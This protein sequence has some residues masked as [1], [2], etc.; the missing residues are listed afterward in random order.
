MNELLAT[1][2]N[3]KLVHEELVITIIKALTGS[4]DNQTCWGVFSDKTISSAV[5][6]YHVLVKLPTIAACDALADLLENEPVLAGVFGGY[7]VI[8]AT[9]NIVRCPSSSEVRE[10]VA[11]ADATTGS[12]GS[13]TLTCERLSAAVSVPEWNVAINATNGKS[14]QD[15]EQFA[16]RTCTPH[17]KQYK[18]ISKAQDNNKSASG[19]NKTTYLQVIKPNVFVIDFV[20]ERL[21]NVTVQAATAEC[22]ARGIASRSGFMSALR[23]TARFAPSFIVNGS[24]AGELQEVT[25]ANIM[26]LAAGYA[27]SD[28]IDD[29]ANRIPFSEALFD[30]ATA[31][32][33]NNIQAEISVRRTITTRATTRDD[34]KSEQETDKPENTDNNDNAA[35]TGDNTLNDNCD[36]QARSSGDAINNQDPN[37]L[38]RALNA[39]TLERERL[40]RVKKQRAFFARLGYYAVLVDK[41]YDSLSELLDECRATPREAAK[42][43][44]VTGMN[45]ADCELIKSAIVGDPRV[46]VP[47]DNLV[48]NM[49]RRINDPKLTTREK[50]EL[51]TRSFARLGNSEIITPHNIALEMVSAFSRE[52]VREIISH[53]ERI[54]ELAS[55]TGEFAIAVVERFT[56]LGFALGEYKGLVCAVPASSLAFECTRKVFELL[57]LDPDNVYNFTTYDLLDMIAPDKKKLDSAA[58]DRVS[59]ILKQDKKPG[60]I[61][62]SD[63]ITE[64]ADKVEIAAIVGNPPYQINT[65]DNSGR[66][67]RFPV[68]NLFIDMAV[69][70]SDQS[71]LITP[72]RFYPMLEK[73]RNNGIKKCL[74]AIVLR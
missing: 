3:G 14:A 19:T 31:V 11:R 1:N 61:A 72:A 55:E 36:D 28:S 13:V 45:I 9:S 26:D 4:L 33:M 58:V 34:N 20:P 25:A 74:K 62:L 70:C 73:L 21:L 24:N 35:V 53:G 12:H 38:H 57:G 23:K 50:L 15:Y 52:R 43:A 59:C 65:I 46:S 51:F 64:G 40:E 48:Y 39:Y 16:L 18:T 49:T 68:Y 8:R 7:A 69:R 41:P 30:G 17:T 2:E 37:G 22:A 63:V 56:K 47:V 71:I 6:K 32:L 42:L 54:V 44:N 5:N 66:E 67:Q 60:E 27:C 29:A 10:R